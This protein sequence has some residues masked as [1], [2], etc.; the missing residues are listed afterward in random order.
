[1][2][3]SSKTHCPHAP[4]AQ[5]ALAPP[6]I[7]VPDVSSQKA[8]K[9]TPYRRLFD[10]FSANSRFPQ[11]AQVAIHMGPRLGNPGSGAYLPAAPDLTTQA[12]PVATPVQ[13]Y[14]AKNTPPKP[15]VKKHAPPLAISLPDR[16]ISGDSGLQTQEHSLSA[17][18]SPVPATVLIRGCMQRRLSEKNVRTFHGTSPGQDSVHSQE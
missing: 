12:L 10:H 3:H 6:R 4:C 2:Q 15:A 8:V 13:P 5:H 11:S 7:P 18:S 17:P 16:K 9:G 14:A 1:M